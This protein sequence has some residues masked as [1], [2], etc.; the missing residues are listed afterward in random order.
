MGFL[1]WS[2]SSSVLS[3]LAVVGVWLHRGTTCGWTWRRVGSLMSRW[4]P[5]SNCATRDR[6]RS[7]TTR[8][9]WVPDRTR[10]LPTALAQTAPCLRVTP[11]WNQNHVNSTTSGH[12][13]RLR[14][15]WVFNANPALVLSLIKNKC[16]C[17]GS[18]Q[19][20]KNENGIMPTCL[21]IVLRVSLLWTTFF[22]LQ[23]L[24]NLGYT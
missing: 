8:T 20:R 2:V 18:K 16:V 5:W 17:A 23:V 9:A 22:H 11:C 21:A 14:F 10:H 13:A 7:W 24:C 12:I 6:P 3:W 4:E 1:T 15:R 19:K